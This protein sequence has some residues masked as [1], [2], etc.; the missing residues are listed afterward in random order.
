MAAVP[1][2]NPAMRWAIGSWSFFI[3]ENTL[4]SENRTALISLLGDDTYHAAYGLCSTVAMGSVGY[5]YRMVRCAP[6][7][8]WSTVP[9][10]GTVGSFM[11]LSLGLGMV[12][13]MPPKLQIPVE[14]RSSS[15]T[16]EI[17]T[18]N[19]TTTGTGWKVRCP[20]DFTDNK[21]STV[22]SGL[23]RISRHPGLWSLGLVGLGQALLVPS[24]PQRIWLSMP[25]VVAFVGGA[26][27]DSRYRR[28]MGGNLEEKYESQTSN[29]PFLAML[30]GRQGEVLDVCREMSEEIKPLNAAIAVGVAGIWV[31]RRGRGGMKV[32]VR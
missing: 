27:T 6:P 10:S 29:V 26:H 12:S 25:L 11:C 3:L 24:L 32:P 5:A 14:Y 31:L 21:S 19:N 30:S 1:L 4:L 17:A 28:G 20:F 7:L 15:D 8:L 22:V 16:K 23:D 9:L 2:V 13:Q 18:A